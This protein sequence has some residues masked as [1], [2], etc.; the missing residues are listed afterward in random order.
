MQR[1]VGDLLGILDCANVEAHFTNLESAD[2]RITRVLQ[3]R[4]S[5]ADREEEVLCNSR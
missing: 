1:N 5:L 3:R 4:L 2:G